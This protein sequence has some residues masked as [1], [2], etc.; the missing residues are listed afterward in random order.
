MQGSLFDDPKKEVKRNDDFL[1]NQLVKLGDMMGDGLHHESDGKWIE[2]EYKAITKVLMPEVFADIRKKKRD[3]VDKQMAE[4]L[5]KN[6]CECGGI[7]AQVRKGVKV[8][9][10]LL[11]GK[12]YRAVKK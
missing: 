3:N 8:S 11:C 10:C 2:K 6:K 12:K 1:Y 7:L 9:V 5:L 4:L